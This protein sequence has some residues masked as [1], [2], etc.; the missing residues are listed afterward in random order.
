VS[1]DT[2]HSV[3]SMTSN[4]EAFELVIATVVAPHGV[5]P[6]DAHRMSTPA[7]ELE[8]E[9]KA[10]MMLAHGARHQFSIVQR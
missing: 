9:Q 4:K 6:R 3:I 10:C 8:P 2:W 1:K 7:A 5:F